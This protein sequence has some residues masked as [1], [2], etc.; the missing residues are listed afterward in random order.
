M[1]TQTFRGRTLTEARSFATEAL[2]KEAV[3][4]MTRRVPRR[5]L[6]GLL[7]LSDIE[8]SATLPESPEPKKGR[9]LPFAREVYEPA[10]KRS[11][12]PPSEVTS[13]RSELRA[14][15]R[16]VRAQLARP[17]EVSHLEKEMAA[18]RLL[19]SDL[20]EQTR[21]KDKRDRMTALVD[22]LGLFGPARTTLLRALRAEGK[23][24]ETESAEAPT[25]DE[26]LR[27]AL[28][29][30]IEVAPLPLQAGKKTVIT[31]VG[32]A[33]VGK[34]T[35]AAKLAAHAAVELGLSVTLVCCDTFRVGAKDQLEKYA[36]ALGATFA[37]PQDTE[38]LA[39]LL[40][41]STSDVVFVDTSGQHTPENDFVS[42]ALG[43]Q[44]RFESKVL[45][46]LEASVRNADAVRHVAR[47]AYAT[48]H[49]LA[50]TKLDETQ[51]PTGLL[52]AA[53]AA[54]LPMAVLCNGPRVPEDLLQATTGAV[55]SALVSHRTRGAKHS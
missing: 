42:K 12:G 31:L 8:V 13:L 54:R 28:A 50:M 34:T 39:N 46:C 22:T 10:P 29:D 40:A 51:E 45:L 27:D 7:G 21:P 15:M 20:A 26:L 48:P 38:S 5:G 23:K 25:D 37:A 41:T 3:V 53:F 44:T 52:H 33:G 43:S 30:L 49:L 16:S 9:P 19:L 32:P 14:E 18:M 17:S 11:D 2:G 36:S 1:N 55:V 47:Y 35:T 24:V 6:P 4:L